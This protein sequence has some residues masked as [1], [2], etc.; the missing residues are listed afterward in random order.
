MGT[1]NR[2][3]WSK[4]DIVLAQAFQILE[5]ERCSQCGLPRYICGN[6]SRDVDFRIEKQVCYATIAREKYEK[7]EEKKRGKAKGQQNE[8]PPG[9]AVY[10]SPYLHSGADLS[11]LRDPYYEA[12]WKRRKEMQATPSLN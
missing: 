5:N 4:W 11:T 8:A 2:K 6:D 1:D 10:P 3:R 9:E 12:E 7:A